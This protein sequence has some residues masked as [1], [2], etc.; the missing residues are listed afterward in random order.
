MNAL[1]MGWIGIKSMRRLRRGRDAS[2]VKQ[3]KEWPPNEIKTA[4]LKG[5]V[6]AFS[7]FAT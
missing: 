5:G 3:K 7:I 1:V 2:D 4:T 6:G